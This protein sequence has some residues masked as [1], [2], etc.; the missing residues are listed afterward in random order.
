MLKNRGRR[1]LRSASWALSASASCEVVVRDLAQLLVDPEQRRRL[2]GFSGARFA[3][4]LPVLAGV[5]IP[6][7]SPEQ[8]ERVAGIEREIQS[9]QRATTTIL[10]VADGATVPT[11]GGDSALL[12]QAHRNLDS[13]LVGVRLY[14]PDFGTTCGA[15]SEP[16]TAQIRWHAML[17]FE[18]SCE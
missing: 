15:F 14:F 5:T 4:T 17:L 13:S 8:E 10:E 7:L 6:I 1:A 16:L 2:P 11:V 18:V 12:L 3:T 9:A